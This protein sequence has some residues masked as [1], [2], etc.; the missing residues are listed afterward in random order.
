MAAHSKVDPK[1]DLCHR[2]RHSHILPKM[3]GSKTC[4]RLWIQRPAVHHSASK[5]LWDRLYVGTRANVLNYFA[6]NYDSELA[7]LPTL[8]HHVIQDKSAVHI[9]IRR[10]AS[11]SPIPMRP[12]SLTWRDPHGQYDYFWQIPVPKFENDAS[13]L[14]SEVTTP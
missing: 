1:P 6:N 7:T 13:S 4:K 10:G 12:T 11:V 5:R 9:Y 8:H 3:C 14:H 2:G